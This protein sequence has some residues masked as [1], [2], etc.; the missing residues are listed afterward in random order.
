MPCALGA[1][2]ACPDRKVINIE[3]DGSAMYTLQALWSQAH[4]K[5]NVI[6]LICSN[7]KYFT[8]EYECSRAG[9]TCLGNEAKALMSL[10]NPPLDWVNI[11][12]GMGVPAAAVTTSEELINE[13]Q[14]A[15][16]ESGP[17]LIEVIL[18]K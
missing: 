13:F 4:E 9:Y 5:A 18:G 12:R 16:K 15:L 8:I 14:A 10:N 1:A 7:R 17:H 2:L 11:S 3:A 6:T